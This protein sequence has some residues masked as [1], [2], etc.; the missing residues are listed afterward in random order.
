MKWIASVVVG[1]SVAVSAQQAPTFRSRIDLVHLD[2]SVLDG[3]RRPV[4]GLGPDDFTILED[5]K[6]QAIAVFSAVEVPPTTPPKTAWMRDVARDVR[7][8][9]DVADRRLFTIIVDDVRMS[10]DLAARKRLGETARKLIDGFGP[11]DL[12]SVIFTMDNRN[13]QDF[14]S[15]KARLISAID[16]A[17]VGMT[18]FG[19]MAQMYS[20][21]SVGVIEQA[22]KSLSELPDRRKVI[23]YLGEGVPVDLDTVAAPIEMGFGTQA[24]ALDA[25]SS[26]RR[27]MDMMSEAFRN[28]ARANIN[29]YTLDVCG[30]RVPPLQGARTCLQGRQVDY[31]QNLAS[32]TG[33]RA[34]VNTNDL[35][36]AVE[37]I[38]EENASYYLLGYQPSSPS[39][40]GKYRQLEVRIN[41]PGLTIRT[42]S[43]YE[44]EKPKDAAR[45]KAEMEKKPL[46]AALSGLLPKGD[47]PLE[48]TAAAFAIP[49][50]SD[51][52]VAVTLGVHQPIRES[53]VRKVEH[54][55]FLVSAFNTDGKFFGAK[56]LN[57]DVTI[58]ADA[59]GLAFYEA[60]ARL[61]LKPGRYQLRVAGNVGSITTSGSLYYDVDVPDFDKAPVSLSGIAMVANP[62]PM[63]AP[64][65]A[66][67]AL[68]PVVPTTMRTFDVREQAVAF[69]RV[70][71]GGR[72]PMIQVPLTVR[73]RNERDE[74]VMDRQE[75]L[76]A[77]LFT[78]ERSADVNIGLPIGRLTPGEYLL[79][80]ETGLGTTVARRNTRFS[81]R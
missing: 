77:T 51:A 1:L 35:G 76:P 72:K 11:A 15:D 34:A 9:Q 60:Q 13:S 20:R 61:D 79:T 53:A 67:K 41:R 16:K 46:G 23:V 7:T 69:L 78:A 73:L 5:D 36:P 22:V 37:K 18:D 80:I 30:L 54:V 71:Q 44:P 47:L 64:R 50:K 21:M 3:R 2:V 65:D 33:G 17:T 58:R 40:D 28:A 56:R 6:P 57:A 19:G 74:L 39:T 70:Y 27:L 31:L 32:S 29:I 8:N 10:S 14:T 42:R 62:P 24:G 59:K 68:L 52:A 43:G 38:F 45:K 25:A 75:Q 66:F 4:K 12:V 48:L 81:V 26:M 55:D 49:G 63:S